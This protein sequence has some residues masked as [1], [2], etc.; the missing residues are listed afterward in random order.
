M[1]ELD[2][3]SARPGRLLV[4]RD[5]PGRVY[6]RYLEIPRKYQQRRISCS[7]IIHSVG[8]GCPE[9]A[10]EGAQLILST[11]RGKLFKVGPPS[12]EIEVESIPPHFIQAIVHGMSHQVERLPENPL[13]HVSPD[14]R[15]VITEMP[16]DEE[17]R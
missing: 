2:R 16:R 3:I 13:R 6:S 14:E 1:L 9:W 5:D 4:I 8:E 10:V 7:A 11:A 15:E 17:G 12:S